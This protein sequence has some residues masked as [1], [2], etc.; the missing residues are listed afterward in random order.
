MSLKIKEKFNAKTSLPQEGIASFIRKTYEILEEGKHTQIISWSDDGNYL[1][2]KD[3]EEF[4]QKVL[5]IYFKHSN[6]TSFVRQLNMY[7]FHKK[8]SMTS[9]HIYFHELF[10]RGKVDML[11]HIKRKNSEVTSSTSSNGMMGKDV[12]PYHSPTSVNYHIAHENLM[13]KQMNKDCFGRINALELRIKDIARENDVLMKRISERQDKEEGLQSAFAKFFQNNPGA[14]LNPHAAAQLGAENLEKIK[15]IMN[16]NK[17]QSHMYEKPQTSCASNNSGGM[18]GSSLTR[19]ASDSG[20]IMD[21][22]LMNYPA[23][24]HNSNETRLIEN[25]AYTATT[26]LTLPTRQP[27]DLTYLSFPYS[28]D[29]TSILGK[30]KP[31]QLKA[32]GPNSPLIY[33]KNMCPYEDTYLG[34]DE[35]SKLTCY[36][37]FEEAEE[38]KINLMDFN[39]PLFVGGKPE[40]RC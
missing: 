24:K 30:R 19:E 20:S 14:K 35:P 36:G 21:P 40:E 28:E 33:S 31:H 39:T 26:Q 22:F 10:K 15:M 7:N 5:P 16:E 38:P 34:Y 32:S 18:M 2:I 3:A 37:I 8:R 27:S 17:F 9:E 25:S 6:F 4:S 11:R 1:V 12:D 29:A 13:L 23:I